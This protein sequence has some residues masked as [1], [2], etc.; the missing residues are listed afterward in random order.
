[1]D[2]WT[3]GHGSGVYVLDAPEPE[4]TAPEVAR[5]LVGIGASILRLAEIGRSLEDV[6]L[7]LV[8]DE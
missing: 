7:E 1:V 2:G 4:A 8:E 6:Y 5:T 3:N